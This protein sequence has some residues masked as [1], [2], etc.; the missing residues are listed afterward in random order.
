MIRVSARGFALLAL[1]AGLVASP[2]SADLVNWDINPTQSS[3]KLSI[4]DQAVTIGTLSATMRLR[5]QNNATWST[6]TA[7]VDG[8]LATDVGAGISSIQFLGGQS[9]LTGVNTGNYRPNPAAYSTAVTDATNSAGTFTNTSSAAAVYAAR[10]NASVSILT[11]NI[12][13][14][15]FSNVSYDLNSAVLPVT[16]TSFLSNTTTLGLADSQINFDSVSASTSGI[17]DTIGNTGPITAVNTGGAAGSVIACPVLSGSCLQAGVNIYRITVPINLPVAVS[18]SGVNL[19]GTAT[20][21]LVG[22]AFIPEPAT[23]ALLAAGVAG[24]AIRGRRRS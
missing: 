14:I 18:L 2:A 16:G 13:M 10:V 8:L 17:G 21:S 22:Y 24:L 7:P 3:F 1:C 9:A 4:P 20:G 11:I 15:S 5:N 12:G 19:N 23:F 6:N